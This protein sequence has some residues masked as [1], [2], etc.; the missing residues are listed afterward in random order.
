MIHLDA[1]PVRILG[2]HRIVARREVRR[3][4]GRVHDRRPQLVDDEAMD[5]VDVFTAAGPQAQMMEAR[6]E[7]VETAAAPRLG[8]RAHEDARAAPDA[9]DEAVIRAGPV[10]ETVLA[11]QPS[12]V[13]T[14]DPAGAVVPLEGR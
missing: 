10:A 12:P 8:I 2:Q 13:E 3:V 11:P 14:A 4:L 5:P 9:V 7:L 6:P 1:D